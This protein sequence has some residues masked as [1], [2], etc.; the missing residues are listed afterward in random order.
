MNAYS[1]AV[2]LLQEI[3]ASP[4]KKNRLGHW[5]VKHKYAMTHAKTG[6]DNTYLQN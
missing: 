1:V 2:A 3:R 6:F 4:Y 5:H